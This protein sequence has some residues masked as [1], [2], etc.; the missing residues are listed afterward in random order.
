[1]NYNLVAE[2]K[3]ICQEGDLSATDNYFSLQ[4]INKYC[5]EGVEMVFIKGNT[6]WNKGLTRETDRRVDIYTEKGAIAKKGQIPWNKGKTG[7]YSE[8]TLKKIGKA[9]RQRVPW[10]KGKKVFKKDLW[11]KKII[12]G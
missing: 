11:V 8:S 9:S 1:M 6:P 3:A 4:D 10:N 2:E 7:V 5:Q 12:I